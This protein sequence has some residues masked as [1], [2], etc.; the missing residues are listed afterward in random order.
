MTPE[1]T[2]K[3]EVIEDHEEEQIIDKPVKCNFVLIGHVDHGKSTCGGRLLVDTGTVTENMIRRA[4]KDAEDNKMR[5]WWLAYLLDESPEERK[6]G[7]THEYIIKPIDRGDY[8][9]NMIDVPG[10]N[11]F[12]TQMI[13]GTSK[14]DIAVLICSAKTG[15]FEKG[16][17]GQLYEHLVLSRCMGINSLIIG[18]NKIDMIGWNMEDHNK[19]VETYNEIKLK[20]SRLIKK[21]NFKNVEYVPISAFH[22]WNVVN[23]LGDEIPLLNRIE[24]ITIN[25]QKSPVTSLDIFR[26][27]CIFMNIKTLITIGFTAIL[28]SGETT[29]DCTIAD[30]RT[31]NSN[32]YITAKDTDYIDITIELPEKVDLESYIIIRSNEMTLAIGRVLN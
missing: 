2:I 31:K 12:I 17:K 5:S 7:K 8:I 16:L 18:V 15:E 4:Q 28:H 20:I 14:A 3:M 32:T 29:S 1:K 30:I 25:N 10:H 26:A 19:A 11:Q 27:K 9:I 13:Y 6:K 23:G 22:G 24:N 21:L